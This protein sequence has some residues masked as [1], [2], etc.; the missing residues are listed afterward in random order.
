MSHKLVAST[1]AVASIAI[2]IGAAVA[3]QNKADMGR[4]LDD[5]DKAMMKNG[6]MKNMDKYMG[7]PGGHDAASCR[8]P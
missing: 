5:S 3:G 1:L 6:A 8:R 2:M 4:P 7:S